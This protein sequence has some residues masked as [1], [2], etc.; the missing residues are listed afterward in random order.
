MNRQQPSARAITSDRLH[1]ALREVGSSVDPGYLDEIV[2]RA[3]HTRQRPAWTYPERLLPMSIAIRREAMPRA[4]ILIAALLLLIALI[5]TAVALTGSPTRPPAPLVVTNGMIAFPSGSNIEA[6]QPDGTGRRVL[7]SSTTE[8][9]D[10]SFSPDGRRFAYWVRNGALSD[11][12]IADADGS[13]PLRAAG[14]Y[15]DT[16]TPEWSPDGTRIAF[17]APTMPTGTV[18]SCTGSGIQNGDFCS[19]RIFI[20]LADGSGAHQIGDPTLDARGVSWSPDGTTIA[21]GGGNATP[22]INVRPYL[23]N[24]D[25]T[26]VRTLGAVRGTD[27]AFVQTGWSHDGSKI[28]GQASAADNLSEQDIWVID[29]KTGEA[30]D[31]G[32]KVGVDEIIPSWAPDRD[33][34]VWSADGIILREAGRAPIDL[35]VPSAGIPIWSP[36]GKLVSS[37]SDAGQLVVYDLRGDVKFTIAGGIDKPAWQ[38]LRSGG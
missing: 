13:H 6:V 30:T 16:S 11:L 3:Q 31:V 4:A 5:A 38:A 28:V 24:S 2:A 22:G 10:L 1:A 33:A 25:G 15:P 23:M 29:A 20:A 34:L 26:N 9:A 18:T 21:F 17:S 35:H 36:D 7:V 8:V 32:A 27:W 19:S 12:F 37:I 14:G